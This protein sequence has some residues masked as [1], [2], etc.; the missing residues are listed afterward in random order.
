[1]GEDGNAFAVLARVRKALKESGVPQAEVE[2]F[3][4]EAMSGDYNHLLMTCMEW[5]EEFYEE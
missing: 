3:T 4:K 1:V 5:V 2:E